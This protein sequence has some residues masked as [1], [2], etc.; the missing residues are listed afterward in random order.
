MEEL[1]SPEA[2]FQRW[3]DV[4]IA[5]CEAWNKKGRITAKALRTIKRKAGFSVRRIDTIE[6]TVK[7]DVISFLTSVAEKV[8]PDSRFIHM[9]LT[10]SD[11]VDTA[12]AMQMRDA[13]DA[14][15][16]KNGNRA[17]VFLANLGPIAEHTVRATWI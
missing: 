2:K 10:S 6:K 13:A 11:V 7:H 1:W 5:A 9:G 15:A 17:A 3:L 8:G 16:Q 12:Y 14:H 4:E